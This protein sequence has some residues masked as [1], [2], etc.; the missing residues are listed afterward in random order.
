MEPEQISIIEKTDSL[1]L[2]ELETLVAAATYILGVTIVAQ[3]ER[4]IAD[5]EGG[6]T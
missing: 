6:D 1:S 3:M 4:D 5:F 2:A